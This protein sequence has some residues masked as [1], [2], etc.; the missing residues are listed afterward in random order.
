MGKKPE[1]FY[2]QPLDKDE[3][4]LKVTIGET[5]RNLTAALHYGP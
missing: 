1:H 3:D 5:R 4:I 2:D